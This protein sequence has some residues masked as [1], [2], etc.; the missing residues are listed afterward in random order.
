MSVV[1]CPVVSRRVFC[2]NCAVD[3]KLNKNVIHLLNYLLLFMY[4][5]TPQWDH[6][7][8]RHIPH[9]KENFRFLSFHLANC[10]I[11]WRSN[12]ILS[13]RNFCKLWKSRKCHWFSYSKRVRVAGLN[14]NLTG[15]HHSNPRPLFWIDCPWFESPCQ[16]FMKYLFNFFDNLDVTRMLQQTYCGL[17]SMAD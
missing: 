15:V 10:Q 17:H 2:R 12:Y 14:A 16:I 6:I 1:P 7:G 4:G 9:G 5:I 13:M 11:S 3:E 8:T